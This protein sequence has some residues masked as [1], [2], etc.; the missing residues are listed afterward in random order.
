MLVHDVLGDLRVDTQGTD[1]HVMCY[2]AVRAADEP[3][4]Q[5]RVGEV[6]TANLFGD[7]QLDTRV[8]TELCVPASVEP[9]A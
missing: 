5:K 3:K 6:R 4:H 9:P 1:L 2:K 8:E 7:L